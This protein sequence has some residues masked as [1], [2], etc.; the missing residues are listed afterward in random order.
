MKKLDELLAEARAKRSWG[1]ITIV[2][3]DGKPVLLRQTTQ[4]KVEE[5]PANENHSR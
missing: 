1:E 3:K 4:E 2:L 5:E